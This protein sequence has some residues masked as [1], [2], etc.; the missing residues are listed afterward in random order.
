VGQ[1]VVKWFAEGQKYQFLSCPLPL[2]CPVPETVLQIKHWITEVVLFR[3]Y[4]LA[5]QIQIWCTR[6]W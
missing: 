2:I 1:K 5:K 4:F 3:P 6:F